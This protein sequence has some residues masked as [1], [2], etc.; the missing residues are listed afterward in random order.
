[1]LFR[2][3]SPILCQL[4]STEALLGYI[5]IG[6]NLSTRTHGPM[7]S[8]TWAIFLEVLQIGMQRGLEIF[9]T[10][11]P[12]PHNHLGWS[13]HLYF[14]CD[15]MEVAAEIDRILRPDRWFVLRDTTEM[16][17]KMRPV[18]KSLHYETVVVKQQFLVAKKGF[19]RPGK[20]ASWSEWRSNVFRVV[21][22]SKQFNWFFTSLL[23]SSLYRRQS[24]IKPRIRHV[25]STK[26]L[27]R[28]VSSTK[29]H[30]HILFMGGHYSNRLRLVH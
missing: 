12:L 14:R 8:F 25:D 13:L 19:W 1:M 30:I 4:F 18:L 6:V 26:Y 7:I 5:M 20:W 2:S 15:I 28:T 10:F 27:Y 29:I 9:T 16:I 3:V 11:A 17:K 22:N 24:L 23:I 21:I